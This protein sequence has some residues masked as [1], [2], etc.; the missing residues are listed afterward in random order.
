MKKKLRWFFTLLLAL[1][2]LAPCALAESTALTLMDDLDENAYLNDLYVAGDTAYFLCSAMDNRSL[3]YQWKV[4]MDKPQLISD[5]LLRVYSG[6]PTEDLRTMY[7]DVE[8]PDLDHAFTYLFTD[9]TRLLALNATSG[10]IFQIIPGE[11]GVTYQDITTLKDMTLFQH[12]EEEYSY[13]MD[14][15]DIVVSGNNLVCMIA[16]YD[17]EF[18]EF[19]RILKV[20]LETGDVTELP[21]KYA[22]KM[23]AYKDGKV[24]LALRQEEHAQEV[25]DE[26]NNRY[27]PLDL[28]ELDPAT[29]TV[30][31]LGILDMD[32]YRPNWTWCEALQAPV[33]VDNARVKA[34]LGL[35]E[36]KQVGYLPGNYANNIGFLGNLI[37]ASTGDTV[38]VREVSADFKA[39]VYLNTQ[40][41]YGQGGLKFAARHPEVPVYASDNYYTDLES[42]A[43]AMVT[44]S[45]SLDIISMSVSYSNFNIMLRKGY[46]ADL[47][48]Y[49]AITEAVGRMYEPFQ[50]AVKNKDGQICAVPISAWSSGWRVNLNVMEEIGLTMDELPTNYVELS[51]FVT[52]WNEEFAH[53]YDM[54]TV[55]STSGSD[56]IKN[57]LFNYAITD[58]LNYCQAQGGSIRF[59]TPVFRQLVEAIDAMD[60]DGILPSFEAKNDIWRDSLF[61]FGYTVIGNF[62]DNDTYSAPLPMSL[63]AD[64]PIV[65]TADVTVVFINPKSKHLDLAAEYV[66]CMLEA[67]DTNAQYVLY[68]D[69]KDPVENPYYESN[70]ASIEESIAD[71]EKMLETA[72]PSDKKDIELN[73][74]DTRKWLEEYK[75]YYRY[76]I[77]ETA[78]Q[79][80]QQEIAPTI[81]VGKPTF[82][83]STKENRNAEL[84]TLI[85]RYRAG[86]IKLDQFI[87]EA[88]QK[89]MMMEMEDQ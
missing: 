53:D 42:L 72:D 80:Y 62:S 82:L 8:N 23:T 39:D 32:T 25:R 18:R 46:C 56:Y 29:G 37:L 10:L 24:L 52:R 69:M 15:R 21:V 60:V 55:F 75:T 2:M 13:F 76:D 74:E 88:D 57:N 36:I 33:W 68:A 86:Q 44:G 67:L 16:D 31:K 14:P 43:Q 64:T 19:N 27:Y 11:G 54:Y 34:Y 4:G 35:S 45:D 40:G 83:N 47:S 12:V 30:N 28:A 7:K 70:I 50:E 17:Q 48:A 84:S 59:D 65:N 51:Q 66:A 61:D 79:R 41:V 49:P 3:L 73:L 6:V 22:L 9:A 89:L 87:R 26:K 71:L 77:S 58:Y 38:Y 5:K 81:A 78:L 85:S 1:C 20:S 63:T